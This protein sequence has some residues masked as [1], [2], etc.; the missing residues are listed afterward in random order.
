MSAFDHRRRTSERRPTVPS[1][2]AALD[3]AQREHGPRTIPDPRAP[4]WIN[5]QAHGAIWNQ[6]LLD[7]VIADPSLEVTLSADQPARGDALERL[8]LPRW[9]LD[10]PEDE[11]HSV[12]RV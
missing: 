5:V 2:R 3:A 7:A 1:L 8:G 6:Q 10:P 4:R 11:G 9:Y 12:K